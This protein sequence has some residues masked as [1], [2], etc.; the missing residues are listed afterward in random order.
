MTRVL[1]LMALCAALAL[2]GATTACDDGGGDSDSDSDSDSDGDSDSDSDGDSIPYCA[3]TCDVAAD[4]V[5]STSSAISD[6]DNWECDGGYCVYQGCNSDTECEDTYMSDLYGCQ[7]DGPYGG[8][9][10]CTRKCGT[11]SDCDLGSILYDTDNYD[12]VGGYCDY[13]GC[14]ED[15]ECQEGMMS[16]DYVCGDPYDW[17]IDTCAIGC[18]T[19]SDCDTGT[20][21][22]FDADNYDCVAGVCVYAGCNSTTECE[23]STGLGAGYECV[24]L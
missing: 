6:A 21:A 8:T 10:T 9:P 18:D 23:N 1:I 14:T 17:G 2:G 4:C 7:E 13:T 22:A 20:G 3:L 19:A 5:P 24:E 16:S 15:V 11:V 12:C